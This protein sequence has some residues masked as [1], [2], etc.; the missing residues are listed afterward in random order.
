ME[1]LRRN[2]IHK[3]Q[4]GAWYG[5]A[6]LKSMETIQKPY[7][8]GPALS[9]QRGAAIRHEIIQCPLCLFRINKIP[10]LQHLAFVPHHLIDVDRIVSAVFGAVVINP[11]DKLLLP[12]QF[13]QPGT[14]HHLLSCNG[15]YPDL[16][17]TNMACNLWPV[18][19]PRVYVALRSRQPAIAIEH[20]ALTT[21]VA[22][23]HSIA[24][25]PRSATSL[26]GPY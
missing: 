17:A 18:G 20:A 7:F 6:C 22:V 24:V 5:I 23:F 16:A 15:A 21:L 11:T 26:A 13:P 4:T 9:A 3:I 19:F 25:T 14:S 10:G 2:T 12:W 1:F 8:S